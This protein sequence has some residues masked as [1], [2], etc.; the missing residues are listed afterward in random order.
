[1][2]HANRVPENSSVPSS[3]SDETHSSA[4]DSKYT[5]SRRSILVGGAT[6]AA[7][8]TPALTVL[9][10]PQK[11]NACNQLTNKFPHDNKLGCS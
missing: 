3:P 8:V 2:N 1:M 11:S 5:P 4:A 9:L 10:M 7:F 6:F